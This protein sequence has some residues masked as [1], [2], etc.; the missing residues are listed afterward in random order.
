[1]HEADPRSIWSRDGAPTFLAV[2]EGNGATGHQERSYCAVQKWVR[3][4]YFKDKTWYTTNAG[5][6][7]DFISAKSTSQNVPE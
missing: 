5:Q 3:S 6:T 4:G 2:P 1:M 7:T